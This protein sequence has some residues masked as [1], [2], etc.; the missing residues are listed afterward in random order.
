MDVSVVDGNTGYQIAVCRS[1]CSSEKL[2]TFSS[3]PATLYKTHN[4]H[5]DILIQKSLQ[6]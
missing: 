1:F 4:P 5:G 6:K 2:F 3:P